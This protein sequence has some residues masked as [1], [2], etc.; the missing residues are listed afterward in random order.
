MTV[1]EPI[2]TRPPGQPWPLA[3]AAQYL[4]VSPKT[5]MRMAEAGKLKILRLGIGRGRVLIPD[6]ELRRIAAG[7]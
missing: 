1:T 4:D 5:I 6:S 2:P 7:E 3:L